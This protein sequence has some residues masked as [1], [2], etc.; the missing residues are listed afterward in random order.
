VSANKS[1]LAF[2][3]RPCFRPLGE[4]KSFPIET[5]GRLTPWGNTISDP[6]GRYC[7]ALHLRP[8]GWKHGVSIERADDARIGTHLI[9]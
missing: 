1:A 3:L 9:N 4:G 6:R 2:E 7:L 5:K 8:L